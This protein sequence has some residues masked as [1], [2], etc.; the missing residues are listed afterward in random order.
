[1]NTK[2]LVLFISSILL[3][4]NHIG[5]CGPDFYLKPMSAAE[6]RSA[7]VHVVLE[8]LLRRLSDPLEWRARQGPPVTQVY[9]DL[10]NTA[11][12]GRGGILSERTRSLIRAYLAAGGSYSILSTRSR[13]NISSRVQPDMITAGLPGRDAARMRLY[14]RFGSEFLREAIAAR[15]KGR[16]LSIEALEEAVCSIAKDIPAYG[17]DPAK[18]F[19]GLYT[20][21]GL[22]PETNP[23]TLARNSDMIIMN[24]GHFGLYAVNGPREDQ[25][26]A[27]ITCYGAR[28]EAPEGP[29]RD[30]FD[31]RPQMVEALRKKFPGAE[32]TSAASSTIN[33]SWVNKA[34]LIRQ[35]VQAHLGQGGTPSQ[36]AFLDDEGDQNGTG[37]KGLELAHELG[38]VGVLVGKSDKTLPA[39]V[40]Q[41][42]RKGPDAHDR[43]LEIQTARLLGQ[44][45]PAATRQE[46][47]TVLEGLADSSNQALAR[48]VIDII[49]RY[50]PDDIAI[51][52]PMN[53][54]QQLG[55]G[56]DASV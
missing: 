27:I 20:G 21:D 50:Y 22:V 13:A 1:M 51:L 54:L 42:D 3:S 12:E 45:V 19:K 55:I 18:S 26:F 14:P 8:S 39:E 33:I 6:A 43:F 23:A 7:K 15:N 29:Q 17:E 34:D 41:G 2:V 37:R 5:L 32:I 47:K 9:S 24:R 52:W 16:Y 30:A 48:Q 25:I 4:S 53:E 11:A 46:L 36:I 49:I 31:P 56:I 28:M 38:I 40:I 10:D 35:A 44:P